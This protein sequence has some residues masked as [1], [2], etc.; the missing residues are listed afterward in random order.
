M[1]TCESKLVWIYMAPVLI[2]KFFEVS[3]VHV[4]HHSWRLCPLVAGSLSCLRDRTSQPDWFG[5]NLFVEHLWL[6]WQILV[7][8]TTSLVEYQELIR[9]VPRFSWAGSLLRLC[10]MESS[11]N[12][13][14]IFMYDWSI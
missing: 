5:R 2:G 14:T 9:V 13:S 8:A 7:S 6:A 11:V 1:V 4:C 3:K 12:T 10:A